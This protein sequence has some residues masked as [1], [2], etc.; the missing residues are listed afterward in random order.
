[1]SISVTTPTCGLFTLLYRPPSARTGLRPVLLSS[2]FSS[3]SLFLSLLALLLLN[4]N[5]VNIAVVF[6]FKI[7]VF[8]AFLY[9]P[10]FI[11]LERVRFWF[12]PSLP[13]AVSRQFF[14]RA[15]AGRW[16]SSVRLLGSPV[17]SLGGL[18]PF[19]SPRGLIRSRVVGLVV[20]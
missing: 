6:A 16:L 15:V 19:L 9:I 17:R 8:S 7:A 20:F 14:I 4:I 18:G 12:W 5:T 2:L 13:S 1:M 10:G 11:S 3:S